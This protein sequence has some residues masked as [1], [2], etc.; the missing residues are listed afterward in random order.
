MVQAL[1]PFERPAVP[2]D[3]PALE[4]ADARAE[5]AEAIRRHLDVDDVLAEL[6]YLLSDRRGT[7][8]PLYALAQHCVTIGTTAETGNRPS[9]SACV[10]AALEPWLQMAIE[11]L[12]VRAMGED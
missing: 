5:V 8:H 12:V 4:A 2:T 7:Q 9:M 10:G 3:N 11:N 6:D 1:F